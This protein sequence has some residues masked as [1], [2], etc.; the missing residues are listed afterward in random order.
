MDRTDQCDATT[1]D[2][3]NSGPDVTRNINSQENSGVPS[4]KRNQTPKSDH[5]L[6]KASS[7]SKDGIRYPPPAIN[8]DSYK[9]FK[10]EAY[11]S[12]N[13]DQAQRRLS[14]SQDKSHH[15]SDRRYR[16]RDRKRHRKEAERHKKSKKRRHHRRSPRKSSSS[17]KSEGWNLSESSQKK[18]T[19]RSVSKSAGSDR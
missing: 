10:G 2:N 6:P 17:K 16:K 1:K 9:D 7:E 19:K 8:L 11:R 13:K 14:E 5:S 4:K 18:K 3:F 15:S 12:K